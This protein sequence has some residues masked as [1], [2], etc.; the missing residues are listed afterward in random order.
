MNHE[1]RHL[2]PAPGRQIVTD[3]KRPA[4]QVEKKSVPN[5]ASIVEVKRKSGSNDM[6][7]VRGSRYNRR[8]TRPRPWTSVARL[9]ATPSW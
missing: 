9:R 8:V 5:G 6:E 2:R 1:C 7:M 3:G 4:D